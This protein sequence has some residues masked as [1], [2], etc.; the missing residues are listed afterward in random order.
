MDEKI[1]QQ[2][3]DIVGEDHVSVTEADRALHSQDQ[4]TH[5]PVLPDVVIWPNSTEAV[6]AVAKIAYTHHI[7][8][9]AW[10]A[11]TSIEGHSIPIKCGITLNFQRMNQIL[12]VHAEDFQVT[13]QPGIFRKELE[14]Q[15]ARYGLM[16][17]PDPGANASIG[18][19][20]ANNAAGI[21]T[22]KYGAT[23]DNVLALE[24]VMANGEVIN[25]GSRSIKQSAG[26]D[27]THLFTGSEGTLGLIT[28]ATLKL[29]PIPEHFTTATIAF[30]TVEDAAEAVYGIIGS[31]LEPAALELIHQDMIGWMNED[32]SAGLTVAPS[33]MIEFSGASE[34]TVTN[35]I[36]MAQ[37]ISEEIGCLGFEGGLGRD[38]RRKMW[39]FRH[40]V[41]ERL[42]R[43]F[44]GEHWVLV[45]L[46]VPISNFPKLV[47]YCQQQIYE[48]GFDGRIIGHAGDGNMHCGLHFAPTDT[49]TRKR[50]VE[51]GKVMVRK[52]LALEGTCTG[53]HGIGLGK[54]K[55][56]LEEHGEPALNVMRTIK[57]A[58]DPHNILNPGKI[59][60]MDD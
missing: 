32:A 29:V 33:L 27:L 31:G 13:V 59:L 25:T 47:S 20:L 52:A 14:A 15:L 48:Y 57:Q 56:M 42:V 10:G 16:F 60:A 36:S 41:R 3:Y 58:L 40:G 37:A 12:A 1:L 22:V 4:S 43:T 28:A 49:K 35:A 21:R 44:P 34:E 39:E 9:T 18:G 51:L 26:Y 7:P 53:E 38:A 19:M 17:A 50:A 45:D 24:V 2:L 6:S 8:I 30:S 55:Y 54:Q 5:P 23:R 46:A 11:G